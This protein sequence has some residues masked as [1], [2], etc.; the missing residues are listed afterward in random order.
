MGGCLNTT[1]STRHHRTAKPTATLP[2][3]SG[4]G[5][6][7]TVEDSDHQGGSHKAHS[8]QTPSQQHLVIPHTAVGDHMVISHSTVPH[9]VHG[10]WSG[11]NGWGGIPCAELHVSS[12]QGIELAFHNSQIDWPVRTYSMRILQLYMLLLK[13]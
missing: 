11:V 5:D 8:L 1:T 10:P 7:R 2:Q 6:V 9:C 12:C 4:S 3:T 13:A